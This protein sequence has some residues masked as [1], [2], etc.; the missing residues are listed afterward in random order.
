[1]KRIFKVFCIFTT[2]CS[3]FVLF[4]NNFVKAEENELVN[5]CKSAYL[6]D[7]DSGEC[8]YK[9]NENKRM[10]I[11][12][13]CKVM[14]LSLC[15]DAISNGNLSFEDKIEVSSN[16]SGM[17]GSQVYLQQNLSYP[18]KDL[19]KSIIVCSANDS[20]VAM[21]EAICGSEA[22]FVAK[23]N[24]KAEELGCND[25]LFSNC[26]GLPKETQYSCA[27]DVAKMFRYLIKNDEY[28]KFSKIWLEDFSHPDDRITTITNTNK[29]IRKYSNC[30]GGKTG[31]TNEAGFC[32]TATAKKGDMRLISVILGADNSDNRFKSTVNLFNYG[33]A[34]YKNKIVLDK[35]LPLND[36]FC[37]VM[38]R[39]ESYCVAPEKNCSIFSA[40][41]E[42]INL[43]FNVIDDKVKAPILKGQVVGRIE[44]YKDNVLYETVNV[45]A[46]ENVDKA[47][48]ADN[49]KKVAQN[50]C[51]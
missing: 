23:M 31:F 5:G 14:T 50:W 44:V 30:D 33:F 49:L 16:A 9:L 26:T 19:I 48:F 43:S 25:T 11:A 22:S 6:I 17:G 39:K 21:A 27:A 29:L 8:V 18:V 42:K 37:A 3:F 51:L 41:N 40:I 12:S 4:K 10:P 34:N 15:F 36:N 28:F 24:T 45:V 46:C 38:G 47:T 32:L 7:Y 13:I 2:I 1:M 20:C 35:N